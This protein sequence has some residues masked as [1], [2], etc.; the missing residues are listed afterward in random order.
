MREDFDLRVAI[1]IAHPRMTMLEVKKGFRSSGKLLLIAL[2]AQNWTSIKVP[3]DIDLRRASFTL[4]RFE[5]R[6]NII[7][8]HLEGIVGSS[9]LN[10]GVGKSSGPITPLQIMAR[11]SVARASCGWDKS[12]ILSRSCLLVSLSAFP[13][14][15]SFSFFTS[16]ETWVDSIS[17][18]LRRE[19]ERLWAI[20]ARE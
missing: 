1:A 18:K 9:G 7:L 20:Q 5:N 6:E 10:S 4:L 2:Y 13:D 12:V 3:V 19:N 15:S 17:G 16:C 11:A 14:V 8:F